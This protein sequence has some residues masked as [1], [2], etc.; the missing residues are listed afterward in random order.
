MLPVDI[1]VHI[2]V[3]GV[4]DQL[5]ELIR[6]IRALRLD[7]SEYTCLKFVILL[8][9]GNLFV[10]NCILILLHHSFSTVGE[11]SMVWYNRVGWPARHIIGHFGHDFMI[12]ITQPTV[13]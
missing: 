10:G 9:P 12:Q 4:C 13:P 7:A 6:R 5:Q 3:G 11:N 2:G 8:N 1:L